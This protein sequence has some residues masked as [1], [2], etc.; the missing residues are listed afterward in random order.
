LHSLGY[1]CVKFSSIIPVNF[2]HF[3]S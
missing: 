1:I 3:K 2:G